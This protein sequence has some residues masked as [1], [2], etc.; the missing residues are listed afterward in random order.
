[1]NLTLLAALTLLVA[2]GVLVFAAHVGGGPVHLLY[3]AAVIL[4]ARRIVAGAPRFLS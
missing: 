4:L 3:A 1:M 2:W